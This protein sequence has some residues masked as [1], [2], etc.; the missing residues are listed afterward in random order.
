[1]KTKYILLI[2][3]LLGIL[4]RFPL[5]EKM[6][7]HW[8]GPQYSIGVVNFDL[9]QETPAPPGYPLY[10]FAGTVLNL[11]LNDPHQSLLILGLV[12]TGLTA[13][14][15]YIVGEYIFSKR[16]GV[17]ASLLYL[18]SPVYFFFGVTAYPYGLVPF[19][20][21]LLAFFV[22]K[23]IN[24]KNTRGLSLGIAYGLFLG[25][26]PQDGLNLLPLMVLGFL[27]LSTKE[28]IR[29]IVA[30]FI[31]VL[32]WFLPVLYLAGGLS[33]Y[34]EEL[35][36]FLGN[37]ALSTLG[38]GAGENIRRIAKGLF[39]TLGISSV[40]LFYYPQRI[41]PSLNNKKKRNLIIY[42]LFWIVPGLLSTVFVRNDHSGYQ[43]IYM[44]AFVVLVANILEKLLL[45][46]RFG[47]LLIAF[48]IIFN[49]LW[50]FRDRDT[51]FSH[52]YVPTSFHYSE[53]RKNDLVLG[54]KIGY[55]QKKYLPENT[56]IVVP[57]QLF[58][59][60]MYHLPD[61]LVIS[62]A[63]I[64]TQD[65]RYMCF[66]RKGKNWLREQE[67]NCD[68]EFTLPK[69]TKKL[70]FLEDEAA[71]YVSSPRKNTVY[72]DYNSRLTE[73]NTSQ[74]QRFLVGFKSFSNND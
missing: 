67:N 14:M 55:I 51:S 69:D 56:V 45:K 35:R 66:V 12:F 37:G 53:V 6:Q 3:F 40:A 11:F 48:I 21:L 58:R 60:V 18:S 10:I 54:A 1:M 33:R 42:F 4:T 8:D 32:L 63:R 61:F 57:S 7:S 29:S 49:I 2:F 9:S 74:G 30:A 39:L 36:I 20:V 62:D 28:R 15:F 16:T 25:M 71:D 43:M 73:L 64:E 50:F 38:Q 68:Q 19:F 34:I 46:N 65:P 47:Y 41:L 22:Y 70:V 26:R 59:P 52:P 72:L 31:S 17:I 13:V 24:K 44:S 5:L 23:A 27:S